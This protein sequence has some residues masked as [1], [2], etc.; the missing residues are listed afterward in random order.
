VGVTEP[1]G[2]LEL[3]GDERIQEYP[4]R[5]LTGYETLVEGHG[6]FCAY[7]SSEVATGSYHSYQVFNKIQAAPWSE[8][9]WNT[10]N[11]SYSTSTGLPTGAE[12]GGHDG[13][14]LKLQLPYRIKVN[15]Y[16]IQIY[17][18]YYE[19]AP[20]S[21]VIIG[22]NDNNNWETIDSIS[23]SGFT[24]SGTVVTK[25]YTVSNTKYYEY[26]ALV[27]TKL[28]PQYSKAELN[29]SELRFFGTPGPTTL[30]KGSLTLGRSLDVPRVSRYDVDT[31]TPRPEKLILDL[32]T[33]V[34][35]SPTD[36]SGKGNHGTFNGGAKYSAVDKAFTGA[37]PSSGFNGST[38]YIS[39]DLNGISGAYAHT[40]SYWIN[41]V[42]ATPRVAF[43][44]GAEAGSYSFANLYWYTGSGV[45]RG[46]VLNADSAASATWVEDIQDNRWYHVVLTYDGGSSTSSWKF[47]LDGEYKTPTTMSASAALS[48][49]SNP[50][51]RIGRNN[52]TQWYNGMV[53]NPKVYSVALEPSE[54][55]KL[56]NLGRTGRSMVISDTA[57][58]IGKAPEAQLDVRG[59]LAVRGDIESFGPNMIMA[60]NGSL[61]IK[62]Y[63]TAGLGISTPYVRSYFNTYGFDG[64]WRT[65]IETGTY[66]CGFGFLVHQTSSVVAMFRFM[67]AGNGH[68][69][70][71]WIYNSGYTNITYSGSNIKIQGP[72]GIT[73]G[74]ILYLNT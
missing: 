52:T 5:G 62:N 57:V 31:E 45:N 46:W 42:D 47:Y 71:G 43:T 55:K 15:S 1:S 25:N 74:Y 29:F 73:R 30:D 13:E 53:S 10:H 16:Q 20:D 37:T 72:G 66:D 51:Y 38:N 2:Q 14:W 54:V 18:A 60:S 41:G 36:I 12:L 33:T 24:N 27:C 67:H 9:T 3:A 11:P 61:T 59:N 7:A 69:N 63:I 58:G 28:D 17:G 56:Y 26:L 44:L 6:V 39:G 64:A 70:V 8:N 34:N 19:Y 48:L 50:E 21:W 49:P 40:Q 4:P 22:S 32:D 68:K 65:L 23:A 35:S